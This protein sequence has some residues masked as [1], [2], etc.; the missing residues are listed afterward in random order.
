[1]SVIK[2]V[3]MI[4]DNAFWTR[5]QAVIIWA[6]MNTRQF[7]MRIGLNS[8]ENLYRIKRGQNG[9]SRQLADR[10]ASCYPRISRGW[11]LTGEGEMLLK[12]TD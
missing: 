7:S 3:F 4:E 8:P 2:D 10:I 1:M 12:E 11:L 9:I 5:L 6:G